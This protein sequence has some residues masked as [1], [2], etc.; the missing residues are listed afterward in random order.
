[1]KTKDFVML[2]IVIFIG[3]FAALIAWTLLV[4]QEIS[5]SASSN[6]ALTTAESLLSSV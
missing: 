4:K 5:S 6:T 2:L 1:M 3:T